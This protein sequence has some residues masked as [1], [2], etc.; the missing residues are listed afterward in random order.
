[1]T[2]LPLFFFRKEKGAESRKLSIWQLHTKLPFSLI[3]SS[4]SNTSTTRF[5]LWSEV[6]QR[7]LFS[8]MYLLSSAEI[9]VFQMTSGLLGGKTNKPFFVF[10][11][12]FFPSSPLGWQV[13][14][15]KKNPTLTGL[16]HKLKGSVGTKFNFVCEKYKGTPKW[17]SSC[18]NYG[19]FFM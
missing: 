15:G 12:G 2:S 9:W 4:L 19:L 8:Q 13:Q 16:S 17:P 1:M 11:F 18:R 6:Y 10:F 14:R 5:S 3:S 7:A